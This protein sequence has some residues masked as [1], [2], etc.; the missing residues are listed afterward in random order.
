MD[1]VYVVPGD[2][3]GGHQWLIVRQGPRVT[4]FAAS[5]AAGAVAYS[6]A[7]TSSAEVN[8]SA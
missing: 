3:P 8:A 4:I 1:I 7:R 6:I 2:M 5:P